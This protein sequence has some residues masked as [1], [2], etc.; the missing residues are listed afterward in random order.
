MI[1]NFT[2]LLKLVSAIK[3]LLERFVIK[4]NDKT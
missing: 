3:I 2:I 1:E 4:L